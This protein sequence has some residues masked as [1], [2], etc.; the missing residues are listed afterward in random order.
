MKEAN[1]SLTNFPLKLYRNLWLLTSSI[2]LWCGWI[3]FFQRMEC[4][5]SDKFSPAKILIWWKLDTKLHWFL[6]FHAYAKTHEEPN[7]LNS[8]LPRTIPAIDLQ[9][10][11]NKQNSHKFLSLNTGKKIKRRQRTELPMPT[12]IINQVGELTQQLNAQYGWNFWTKTINLSTGQMMTTTSKIFWR[13]P[14]QNFKNF[15]GRTPHHSN[16]SHQWAN[17]GQGPPLFGHWGCC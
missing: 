9:P 8:T 13:Y 17:R 14:R 12:A 16:S 3:S 7:P 2:L 4:Q 11:G 6:P 15:F 5:L 10:A 1:A